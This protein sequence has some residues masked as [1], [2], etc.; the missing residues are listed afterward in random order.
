MIHKM[1]RK[2]KDDEQVKDEAQRGGGRK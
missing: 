1:Q 2:N